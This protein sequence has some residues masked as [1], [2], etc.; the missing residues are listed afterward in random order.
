ME[1]RIQPSGLVSAT[2]GLGERGTECKSQ[3]RVQGILGSD[4]GEDMGIGLSQWT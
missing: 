4:G 2:C 3:P 1:G